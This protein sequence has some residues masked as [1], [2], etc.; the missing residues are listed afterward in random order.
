MKFIFLIFNFLLLTYCSLY[1]QSVPLISIINAN[2]NDPGNITVSVKADN[3]QNV[4]A[5]GIKILYDTTK[6]KYIECNSV[7]ANI[8]SSIYDAVQGTVALAWTSADGRTAADLGNTILYNIKF[9][10]LKSTIPKSETELTFDTEGTM[11]VD[12]GHSIQCQS[13]L[14]ITK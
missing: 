7:N 11:I 6:L 3:F 2:V 1:S 14:R 10:Q 12:C 8:K 4:C 9:S 13:T 5:L